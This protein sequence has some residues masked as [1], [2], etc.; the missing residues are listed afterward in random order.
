MAADGGGQTVTRSTAHSLELEYS[1][2]SHTNIDI[3]KPDLNSNNKGHCF[4][5]HHS[6]EI[7]RSAVLLR[8]APKVKKKRYSFLFLGILSLSNSAWCLCSVYLVQNV[9]HI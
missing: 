3:A 8:S 6:P 1:V 2:K 4:P 9:V 7:S 5:V